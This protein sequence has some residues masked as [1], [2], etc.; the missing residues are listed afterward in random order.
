MSK[1]EYTTEMQNYNRI[2]LLKRTA[3]KIGYRFVLPVNCTVADI[4]KAAIQ[5]SSLIAGE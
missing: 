2:R 1:P 5:L 3:R 4:D